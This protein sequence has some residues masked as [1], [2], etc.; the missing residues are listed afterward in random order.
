LNNALLFYSDYAASPIYEEIATFGSA[1]QD[2]TLVLCIADVSEMPTIESNLSEFH[3]VRRGEKLLL[4]SN[5]VLD[6]SGVKIW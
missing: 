1:F 6:A 2:S 5:K 4:L 3:I